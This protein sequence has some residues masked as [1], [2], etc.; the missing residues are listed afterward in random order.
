M[1]K[2]IIMSNRKK[3]KRPRI[4]RVQENAN[5]DWGVY[6]WRN[7]SDGRIFRDDDNNVLNIPSR[8]MDIAKMKIIQDAAA[9]YGQPEGEAV[10]VPGAQRATEESYK[11]QIERM[12][13]GQLPT[14]NDFNA[15]TDAKIAGRQRGEKVGE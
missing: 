5:T 14:M 4:T 3:L 13:D 10:F 7:K 11:H 9:H 12:K 6:V 2:E 8:R 15:V 1:T